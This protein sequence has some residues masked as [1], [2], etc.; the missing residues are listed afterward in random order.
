MASSIYI[1]RG[2]TTKEEKQYIKALQKFLDENPDAEIKPAKN[3]AQLKKNYDKFCVS[4]V[5]FEETEGDGDEDTEAEA[6]RK[7]DEILENTKREKEHGAFRDGLDVEENDQI[8]D[9]FNRNEPIVRDYVTSEDKFSKDGEETKNTGQSVFNEPTNFRESFS[10]PGDEQD[11]KEQSGQSSSGTSPKK[12]KQKT[13]PLNPVADEM[14]AGKKKKAAKRL[15]EAVIHGTCFV[16]EKG[17]VWY[18]TKDIQESVLNEHINKKRILPEL[19]LEKLDL[20]QGQQATIKEFFAKHIQDA[21]TLLKVTDEGKE[22]LIDSLTVVLMEKG[23]VLTPIQELAIDFVMEVA[24][25]LGAVAFAMQ[26]QASGIVKQLMV[27]TKNG[28]SNTEDQPHEEVNEPDQQESNQ[29]ESQHQQKERP[30]QRQPVEQMDLDEGNFNQLA[31][32]ESKPTK[33]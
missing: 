9:P 5:E 33:E 22:K 30:S 3:L 10:I 14:S 21:N 2:N 19:L 7:L 20:G 23:V 16:L 1:K 24:L 6:N 11:Q 8:T 26:Q 32:G 12:E 13:E 15:A 27:M 18:A 28:Y 4:D 29:Q 25:P 31:V 17:A